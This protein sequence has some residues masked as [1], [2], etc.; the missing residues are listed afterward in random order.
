MGNREKVCCSLT[1]NSR[2]TDTCNSHTNY[3][4]ITFIFRNIFL[5]NVYLAKKQ[6]ANVTFQAVFT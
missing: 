3:H 6:N 2:V 5:F 1:N 4:I